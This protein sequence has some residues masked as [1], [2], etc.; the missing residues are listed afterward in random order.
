MGKVKRAVVCC[1]TTDRYQR[2]MAR[3]RKGVLENSGAR[4]LDLFMRTKEPKRCPEHSDSP[5]SFKAASLQEAANMG[6]ELLLWCD[7][8]IVPIRSLEPLWDKIETEGAWIA[9]NGWTNYEWTA[10]AA[11]PSLFERVFTD[12]A[13]PY[14]IERAKDLNRQI[15]HVVA[16]AFGLNIGHPTGRGIFDEYKR[17]AL[18]TD[19]FKG[20]WRNAAHPDYAGQADAIVCGPADVR[21]HRHDQTALSVLAWRYGVQLT[22]PPAW[23]AYRGGETSDTILVADG[24]F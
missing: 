23:F 20:P 21:G 9:R 5:Y 3:L 17:L 22:D 4:C 15:P 12:L 18:Q 10:E 19:A 24:S 11:Y 7:A 8:S 6:M 14:T 13:F 1:A 16:T 2:G